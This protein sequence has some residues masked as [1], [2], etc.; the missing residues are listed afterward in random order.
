MV[1]RGLIAGTITL[2]I[3]LGISYFTGNWSYVYYLSGT[4][5]FAFVALALGCLIDSLILGNKGSFSSEKE[6][7][8]IGRREDAK[9]F[10]SL[11]VPNLLAALVYIIN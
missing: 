4:L 5:G 11:A 6:T 9:R 7:R 8:K 10:I 2:I 3:V 1:E